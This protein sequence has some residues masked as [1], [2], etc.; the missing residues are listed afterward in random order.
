VVVVAFAAVVRPAFGR[1][2]QEDCVLQV[3]QADNKTVSINEELGW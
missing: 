2:S 3:S 1:L